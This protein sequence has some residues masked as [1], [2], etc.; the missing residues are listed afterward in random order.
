MNARPCAVVFVLLALL[1]AGL[2]GC[3]QHA[4]WV[5]GGSEYKTIQPE[6]SDLAGKKV[7]VVVYAAPKVRSGD[8]YVVREVAQI[9]IDRL[10]A[11]AGE[12]GLKGVEVVDIGKV[13]SFQD[14]HLR[15]DTMDRGELGKGLGADY[16]LFICIE[17][18]ST[19][20]YGDYT[21]YQ[22]ALLADAK[23]YDASGPPRSREIWPIGEQ[24]GSFSVTHPPHAVTRMTDDDRF[25]RFPT[26]E[27]FAVK[28]VR[29]FHKHEVKRDEDPNK[30]TD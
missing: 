9:V 10:R 26:I 4:W 2:G 27:I 28:L 20:R 16:V 24:S 6:C 22:G 5:L 23:L 12:K 7:A 8:P 11:K 21:V 25:V 18:F 17:A 29:K 15:W 3:T 30:P 1:A 14:G 13:E 19:R